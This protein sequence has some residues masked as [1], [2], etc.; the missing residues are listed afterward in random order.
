[1][2]LEL[3]ARDFDDELK[4]VESVGKVTKVAIV[5]ETSICS[6]LDKFAVGASDSSCEFGDKAFELGK[7]RARRQEEYEFDFS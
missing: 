4:Q 3:L 6:I 5:P 2:L 1:M 7:H